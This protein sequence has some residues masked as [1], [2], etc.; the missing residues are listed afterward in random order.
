MIPNSG[1]PERPCC[2][3]STPSD[4]LVTSIKLTTILVKYTEELGRFQEALEPEEKTLELFRHLLPRNHS[5]LGA[6]S[7]THLQGLHNIPICCLEAL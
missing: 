3:Y 7:R 1:L 6:M 2:I 4:G 5:K